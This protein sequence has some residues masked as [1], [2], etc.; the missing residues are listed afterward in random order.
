MHDVFNVSLCKKYFG[1]QVVPSAI[2]VDGEAEYEVEMIVAHRV[3]GRRI[4]YLIRWKG[5]D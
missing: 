1:Q 5:Y 2:E 4:E 3:R